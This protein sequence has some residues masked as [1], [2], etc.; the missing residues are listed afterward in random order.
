MKCIYKG[1]TKN[2]PYGKIYG[3]A[4]IKSS[5]SEVFIPRGISVTLAG[6]FGKKLQIIKHDI[7]VVVEAKD[8]EVLIRFNTD[9][10][11]DQEIYA[12][13]NSSICKELK[14]LTIAYIAE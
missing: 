12:I 1:S 9:I 14:E 11:Y 6:L 4:L 3:T 13:N 10:G 2:I 5:C 8:N 7:G